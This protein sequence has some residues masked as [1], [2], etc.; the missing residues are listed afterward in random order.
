MSAGA[1]EEIYD[2]I[3]DQDW[4][5]P[6]LTLITILTCAA[7][8]Q[9]FW[10]ASKISWA[11]VSTKWVTALGLA[12]GASTGLLLLT[13][14]LWRR[15]GLLSL[16]PTRRLRAELQQRRPILWVFGLV[17]AVL[18]PLLVLGPLG[19]V[20]SGSFVRLATFWALVLLFSCCLSGL[21]AE[22]WQ[23]WHVVASTIALAAAYQAGLLLTAISSFPLSLGWSEASR[24]YYASLFFGERIYG[25][26]IAFPILHPSRYLLQSI[27]FVMPGLPL[28]M[29]RTW[30]VLLWFAIPG[31]TVLLLVRRLRLLAS[32]VG[33]L[34][35]GWGALFLFQGPVYYHLLLGVLPVLCGFDARRFT[36]TLLLVLLG[37]LWCGISRV[38]WYPMP[39]ML[40]AAMYFLDEDM[41]PAPRV[42]WRVLCCSGDLGGCWNGGC[43]GRQRRLC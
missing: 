17:L 12:V 31:L 20:F 15:P 24:Y 5:R 36:R 19:A 13:V 14:I 35:M 43:R 2:L 28:A 4:L 40:A 41:T 39:G 16:L 9:L 23:G 18:Y 11:S 34:V 42:N 3:E 21:R 38:N 33:W 29:H 32:S 30:Q 10:T 37:S 1:A 22:P 8:A 7:T 27:P 25:S 26:R 6:S